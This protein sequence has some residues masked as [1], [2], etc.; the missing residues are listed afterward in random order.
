MV[1]PPIDNHASQSLFDGKVLSFAESVCP[2]IQSVIHSAT[3][4]SMLRSVGSSR[5]PSSMINGGS[6]PFVRLVE[7]VIVASYVQLGDYLHAL[8]CRASR[9]P[10]RVSLE[11]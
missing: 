11:T 4:S 7:Y 2:S 9:Q 5:D 10:F 6:D 8:C 1:C 3:P